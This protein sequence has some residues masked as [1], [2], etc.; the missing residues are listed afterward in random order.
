MDPEEVAAASA[1]AEE[2]K[3]AEDQGT[4]HAVHAE[5]APGDEAA[6]AAAVA[7]PT[8]L[9]HCL[10]SVKEEKITLKTESIEVPKQSKMFLS[11]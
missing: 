11:G 4:C 8:L 3:K 10:C 1:P 5:P 6:L 2:A 7:A 9:S